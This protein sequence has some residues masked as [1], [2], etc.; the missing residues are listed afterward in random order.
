MKL[1]EKR[2]AAA[3]VAV[4]AVRGAVALYAE[5][6]KLQPRAPFDYG[7]D[8][9][10]LYLTTDKPLYRPGETVYA[11]GAL[12]D[13]FTRSP[14]AYG[15]PLFEV[16]GPSGA[17]VLSGRSQ[18]QAGIAPFA[19]QIPED[20]PG[21]EYKLVARFPWEGMPPSECSFDI[22]SYRV[23][24]LKTELEFEKKAYGPGEK[25]SATL[26]ATRAEGGVP[27]GATATAVATVDGVEVHRS[28]VAL[29]ASGGCTVSFSLPKTIGDGEGTLALVVRDGGVQETAAKTIPIAVN[30]I[31]IET[32]P[33]GGDLVSGLETR[34]YFEAR[35]P[36]GKPADMAGRIFC[37]KDGSTVAKFKTDHEGRGKVSFVPMFAGKAYV[38]VIDEPAGTNDAIIL[39]QVQESG[40]SLSSI[41]RSLRCRSSSRRSRRA[42]SRSLLPRRRTA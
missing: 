42:R 37:P 33:E 21:G 15:N 40:F 20:M 30:R 24:R 26:K 35:T 41:A 6:P 8:R 16:K 25:V 13:A 22:R 38:L 12:L 10:L 17:I 32:F 3:L 27:T 9:S 1:K 5:E 18:A 34:L 11:R 23:P 36:K 39:P 2:L 19:W 4:A 7:K 28:E 31:K 14:V 29:D